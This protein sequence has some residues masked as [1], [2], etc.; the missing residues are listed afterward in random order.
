MK[1]AVSSAVS[2]LSVAAALLACGESTATNTGNPNEPDP[3]LPDGLE[4]IRSPLERDDTPD[5]PVTELDQ[6]GASSR[7]FALDLYAQVKPAKGNLFLS[8]YSVATALGML[9]AGAKGETKSEM[10]GAL[11]FDLPEPEL[12]AA[13]NAT[14]LALSGRADELADY[15]DS[16]QPSTGDGLQLNVVNAAFGRTGAEFRMP[17]L[18]VLAE[19]YDTGM[20]TADFADSETARKLINDWVLEQTKDRI[21]ELLPQGS[22]FPDVILVLVN[23]IYFKA[24]WLDPFDPANTAKATFHAAAGDAEVDMMHAALERPYTEGDGY[25]ALELPYISPKVRMLFLLPA[26]G[27]FDEIEGGLDRAFLDGVRGDLSE[28]LVEMSVPKFQFESE[29]ALKP[30]LQSMGMKQAFE[31]GTADLSGITKGPGEIWVDA[32][33]HKA[34]VAIDEQGTEAAAATAV[35]ISDESAPV[36]ATFTLDRPFLF[37]IYDQPTGQILFIGRVLD[38]S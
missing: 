6:F 29:Q 21:D 9:Y 31:Q 7:D 37:M 28:H 33:Y 5:V 8:P 10:M 4:L 12:H 27:R 14:D 16:S 20:F 2:I 30:V 22:I 19:H 24:S 26:E 1:R 11:H 34:F 38:P 23:A 13:F 35:V 25:Q 17:Y 36:P 15:G 32:V 18:D 3:S